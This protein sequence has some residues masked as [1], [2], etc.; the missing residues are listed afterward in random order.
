MTRQHLDDACVCAVMD[1]EDNSV[2]PGHRGRY[3]DAFGYVQVA[4][5][6]GAY[7]VTCASGAYAP[8][9]GRTVQ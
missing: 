8:A 5:R 9:V 2:D 4:P 7:R 6:D 3:D 1:W